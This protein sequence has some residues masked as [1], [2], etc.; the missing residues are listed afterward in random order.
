ML[1]NSRL[2]TNYINHQF[3]ILKKKF[4]IGIGIGIGLKIGIGNWPSARTRPKTGIGPKT[5]VIQVFVF[6]FLKK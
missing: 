4:K 6:H 3:E 2:V 5:Q 1:S